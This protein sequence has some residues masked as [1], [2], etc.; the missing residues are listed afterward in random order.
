MSRTS[1]VVPTTL[2]VLSLAC[3]TLFTRW[4]SLSAF[5]LP[6]LKCQ[7]RLKGEQFLTWKQSE[8]GNNVG[9]R[10]QLLFAE[11]ESRDDDDKD[12]ASR[13][14]PKFIRESS[15]SSDHAQLGQ[16]KGHPSSQTGSTEAKR[17]ERHDVADQNDQNYAYNNIPKTGY[18]LADQLENKSP[19]NRE[20]FETIL[21]P[22]LV[23]FQDDNIMDVE[24]EYDK[25]GFP[26]KIQ[27]VFQS[28]QEEAIIKH[29]GVARIDTISSLGNIGEEPVR[30]LVSLGKDGRTGNEDEVE[31]YAMVDLPPYSER[32]ADNIRT[33][34]DPAYNTTDFL[35]S[36]GSKH[37]A[38]ARLSV[39]LITNQQCIHYD[40][41]PA[42][43]VTRKS[44]LKKWKNAFPYVQVIMYRLDIPRECRE[45]I[46]QVLDGYGPWGWDE[47]EDGI[48]VENTPVVET[49]GKFVETGRPLMTEEWDDETKTKVL[50]QGELPPDNQLED[51]MTNDNSLYS[52]DAIRKREDKYR[53]LAV[54][55]PG[56][57]FGSVTYIFPQRGICCSGYTLPLEASGSTV[58][59][60]IYDDADDESESVSG[61][62]SNSIIPRQQGP[63]LDYQGYLAMSASRPRQMSSALSLINGYIDRFRVVLPARGDVV[64]LDSDTMTRKRELLESVGLYQKIGNIYSR[65]GIAD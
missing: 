11:S 44:D 63:R 12:D 43:Y 3:C 38:K 10:T 46:T 22:V 48:Q 27:K 58:I 35:N 31:S 60:D 49:R 55:T 23:D 45:E 8:N 20:R 25:D 56:L 64:L 54:Y 5:V 1:K 50:K 9:R 41:S 53:L 4:M 21:S 59:E 2:V 19:E 32:L 42:V 34:M 30:W 6:A 65:L 37:T 7:T 16:T 40:S 61:I 52:P 33:F 57:T 13:E 62:G 47:R 51:E 28:D 39:I 36:N 18:S 24:F 15:K 14:I 17:R 26:S 29:Q